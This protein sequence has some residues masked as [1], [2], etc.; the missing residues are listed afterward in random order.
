LK[1][2]ERFVLKKLLFCISPQVTPFA[3]IRKF[4]QIWDPENENS[5][6]TRIADS[7]V[8]DFWEGKTEPLNI[9]NY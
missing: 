7:L 3:F 6:L 2:F 1:H 8:A 9:F 4:L 5:E